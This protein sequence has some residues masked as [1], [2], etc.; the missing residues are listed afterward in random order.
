MKLFILTLLALSSVQAG[1]NPLRASK[2]VQYPV[3]GDVGET[4]YLTPYIQSGDIQTGRDLSKVVDPIPGV[5]EYNIESYSGFLTVN[6][7]TN[8][9]M[10]FW[11][12]PAMDVD[13]LTAPVVIWLQGGPGGTSMFGLLELH[14][15]VIARF[16]PNNP[17]DVIGTFNEYTWAKKANMLY[18][19][20]P[21]GAGYSYSDPEGLPEYQNDVADDLYEALIQ[22]YTLFPEYQQTQFYAFGES[23][24]GKF[25]PTITRKIHDENPTAAIKINIGGMGIGDGFMSPPETAVYANYLYQVG[26]VDEPLRDELLGM[27]DRID[28]LVAGEQWY[29]AWL[30]WSVEFDLFLG[31]MGCPYYYEISICDFPAEEDNFEIYVQSEAVR[32]AIHVGDRPFGV[33][34]GDVYNNMLDD[35]MRPE[36]ENIEFLLNRY[37]TLIYDGNFDII[38]NHSGILEMFAAMTTW[39]GIISGEYYATDR[40]VYNGRDGQTAGYLKSVQNLRMF[41]MRNAGHMVPLS[42]PMYA[43]DMFEDFIEGRL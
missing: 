36:R 32:K 29:L 2:H 33:Q 15:P 18:I 8:N 24:A 6:P 28:T 3:T 34:S 38:C 26:L 43:Q 37:K 39:E 13:P 27:E 22:F 21:V 31:R 35:F 16:D 41:V 12:F 40:T 17:S 11:F 1:Y 20:N 14:G 7:A 42:Q 4:L 23:Y 25:V 30:E 9:N 5:E 19:D 10:F